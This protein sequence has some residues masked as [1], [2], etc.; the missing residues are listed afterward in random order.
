MS[1]IFINNIAD[2]TSNNPI[3][4]IH[5]NIYVVVYYLPT[6]NDIIM[7]MFIT[8]HA[9]PDDLLPLVPWH[10][11]TRNY[12]YSRETIG[13]KQWILSGGAGLENETVGLHGYL[14][15]KVN[16]ESGCMPVQNSTDQNV[17]SATCTVGAAYLSTAVRLDKRR[18]DFR[19]WWNKNLRH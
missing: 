19:L 17:D 11:Q 7:L 14:T 1:T 5:F 12:F 6:G 16:R 18:R 2:A 13:D 10:P 15:C 9:I 3:E 8:Q 4:K